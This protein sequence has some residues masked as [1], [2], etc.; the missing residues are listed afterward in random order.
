M[1]L[2]GADDFL[3]HRSSGAAIGAVIGGSP[4]SGSVLFAGAAGVLA[5]DNANF[6]WDD[7]N[8]RLG[9]GT[10][11]P[12][13]PLS[14]NPDTDATVILGRLRVRSANTDFAEISHFD[15]TSTTSYMLAGTSGGSTVLNSAGTANVSLAIAGTARWRV[16]GT[17]TMFE[18]V[19]DNALD[20]GATAQRIRRGYFSEYFEITE[21]T[22]P[23]NA[24]ADKARLF[25]RDNGASKTQ[26]CVIFPTGAIQVIATEP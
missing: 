26:L 15:Q 8:N 10:A 9:I 3:A 20:F 22:A 23:A 6:F 19:T 25:V 12:A 7:T 13:A 11:A 5:Q 17:T 18:P 24:P 14:V 16:N 2:F 1:G 21:M 4:T